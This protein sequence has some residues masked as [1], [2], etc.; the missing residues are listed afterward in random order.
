[1]FDSQ[2]ISNVY[3]GLMQAVGASEKVFE[4]IDREP[5]IKNDGALAPASFQGKVEFRNVSFKYPSRSN[6][7][8]LKV[9]T[10]HLK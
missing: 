7:F 4:I 2:M 3:S 8:V 10:L 9:G 6:E 1:M 5:Q